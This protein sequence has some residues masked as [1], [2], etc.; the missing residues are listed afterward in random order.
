MPF[1]KRVVLMRNKVDHRT[2]ADKKLVDTQL[3][4]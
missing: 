1:S 3:N 4:Y 2:S